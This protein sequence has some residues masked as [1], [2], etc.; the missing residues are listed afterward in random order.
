MKS[1]PSTAA[2]PGR[3]DLAELFGVQYF[4]PGSTT[5][6]EAKANDLYYFRLF[7]GEHAIDIP[8]GDCLY[9][10]SDDKA[11]AHVTRGPARIKSKHCATLI[12]G[13][14]PE[15]KSSGIVTKTNLPYVN[16]C[17]TK[18]V[19]PPER[20]G[21]PTLQILDIPPYSSEQA[22]HIHSTARIAYVLS[23]SGFSIVGLKQ[24]LL[25]E[26][27]YP[28]KI[29]VLHKMAPHHFETE[30]ERLVVLPLHVWSSVGSLETHHPM[31]NGTFQI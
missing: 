25:R 31:F 8:F 5:T 24:K 19:F 28:G 22:H 2:E 18:Q 6:L 3:D 23:G 4:E 15:N 13:Y 12:R 1:A 27:L 7:V 20:L 17:S 11:T 29:A 9:Y 14:M 30:D 16:G 21:D 10:V 26:P